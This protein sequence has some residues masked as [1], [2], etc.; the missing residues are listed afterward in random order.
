MDPTYGSGGTA[1]IPLATDNIQAIDAYP[2][3]RAYDDEIA[4]GTRL[5]RSGFSGGFEVIAL[6]RSGKDD[7]PGASA[8][9][10]EGVA[11]AP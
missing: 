6:A 7:L 1:Q 4:I 5:E 10:R 8:E 11:V 9:L 3:E 2:S